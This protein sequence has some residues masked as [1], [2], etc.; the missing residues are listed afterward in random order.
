MP[1]IQLISPRQK[2]MD[3]GKSSNPVNT[4][5]PEAVNP[6]VASKYPL[7]KV[8][9]GNSATRGMAANTGKIV[10]ISVTNRKP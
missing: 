7:V 2:L 5:A 1:P 8:T 6:E 10:Q 3:G 4:V 9:S